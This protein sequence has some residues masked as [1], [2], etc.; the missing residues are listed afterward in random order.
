MR[1]TL[2]FPIGIVL[3]GASCLAY[4]QNHIPLSNDSFTAAKLN[5]AC[6]PAHGQ[7]NNVREFAEQTCNAY[8]RGL[9][10]GFF[11][12]QSLAERHQTTCVPID[13]PVSN[14]EAITL[15]HAR[16]QAHPE[17]G[18]NSAALV[19]GFAIIKAHACS[20]G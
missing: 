17:E 12:M 14:I 1:L 15:L 19:A 2:F 13:T 4:A 7:P 20:K 5:M 9:A 10:D 8:V 6:F 18:A 3:I 11:L 16:L